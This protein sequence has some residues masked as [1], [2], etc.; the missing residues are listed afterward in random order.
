MS[1]A[2]GLL[3]RTDISAAGP[4]IIGR[5]ALFACFRFQTLGISV[6]GRHLVHV[7]VCLYHESQGA[8]MEHNSSRHDDS[9]LASTEGSQLAL[10]SV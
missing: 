1:R 2:R 6:V 5:A 9:C 10:E 8:G 7:Y 3:L 4:V